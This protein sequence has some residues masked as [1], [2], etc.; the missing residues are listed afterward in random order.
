MSKKKLHEGGPNM[1]V[2]RTSL[3]MR[4]EFFEAMREASGSRGAGR[5][6]KMTQTW[7]AAALIYLLQPTEK[8]L[9]LQEVI[10]NAKL[11]VSHQKGD[12]VLNVAA[13]MWAERQADKITAP[14]SDSSSPA[15][16]PAPTEGNR[17]RP[18]FER[19]QESQTQPE[20]PRRR[21]GRRRA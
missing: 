11:R 9:A 6:G 14:A 13:A 5:N 20:L 3:V 15:A 2:Q 10:Q 8:K 12:S 18:G 19:V 4:R 17:F 21:K 16:P 1:A 7:E